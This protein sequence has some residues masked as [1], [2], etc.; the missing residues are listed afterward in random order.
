MNWFI[1]PW[2][3]GFTPALIMLV[4]WAIDY[5]TVARHNVTLDTLDKQ[6]DRLDK[7]E[8]HLAKRDEQI[9]TLFEK[10]HYHE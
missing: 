8:V 1:A 6:D 9:K 10:K 3:I 7:H 5:Y 4:L 2:A